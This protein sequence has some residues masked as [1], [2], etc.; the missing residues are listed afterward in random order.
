MLRLAGLTAGTFLLV[1]AI[2]ALGVVGGFAKPPFRCDMV[3]KASWYQYGT[4]TASGEA[5]HP[6]GHTAAMMDRKHFGET[7]RV[8]Y[9]HKHVDV[10]VND[11]GD[12]GRLGRIIDLSRGAAVAIGLVGPGVDTVC[13]ERLD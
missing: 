6:N 3:G 5:F 7:W 8:H 1:F 11:T 10:R 2:V 9:G 4:V 12:F 13:L